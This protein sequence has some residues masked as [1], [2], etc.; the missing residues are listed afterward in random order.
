M[1]ILGQNVAE[2]ELFTLIYCSV[3]SVPPATFTWLFNGQQTGVHEAGY[4][5]RSVSYNNSGDYRC[6]ARNDLTG[7]VI[8]VDHSL[9]VKGTMESLIQSRENQS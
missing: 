4:I 9:S 2:V 6:D 8:S 5:I 7:N 3:Q 1:T